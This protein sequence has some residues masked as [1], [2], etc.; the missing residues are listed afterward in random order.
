MQHSLE[1]NRQVVL[2][3]L[4][5]SKEARAFTL[6]ERERDESSKG[7]SASPLLLPRV[8]RRVA[9]FSASTFFFS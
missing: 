4:L 1:S 9:A 6:A 3:H 5:V 2:V 8:R 7:S